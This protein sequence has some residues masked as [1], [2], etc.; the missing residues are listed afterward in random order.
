MH[1]VLLGLL[2]QLVLDMSKMMLKR[3]ATSKLE[4]YCNYSYSS[5]RQLKRFIMQSEV[6]TSTFSCDICSEKHLDL[7]Q[8]L[9]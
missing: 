6:V 1:F 7:F 9:I 4:I 5:F 2:F 8:G 3:T